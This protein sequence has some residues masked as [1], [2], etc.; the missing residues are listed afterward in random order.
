MRQ[1]SLLFLLVFIVPLQGCISLQNK[2]DIDKKTGFWKGL[3][4]NNIMQVTKMKP[5]RRV[6]VKDSTYLYVFEEPFGFQSN[7]C[8]I[9]ALMDPN[10]VVTD[11]KY[12]YCGEEQVKVPLY[13]GYRK[14]ES[15]N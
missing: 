1:L 12:S 15:R 8:V 4:I 6:A 2:E 3:E 13:F 9:M 14:R 7:D 11:I 5:T 10:K